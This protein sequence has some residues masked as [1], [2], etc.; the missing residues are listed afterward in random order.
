MTNLQAFKASCVVGRR[1]TLVA[2]WCPDG[3]QRTVAEN[4]SRGVGF[5][6]TGK[7]GLKKNI[8]YLSWPKSA[9]ISQL[10]LGVF[11]IRDPYMSD[12]LTYTFESAS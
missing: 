12:V 10:T 8:S 3:E 5:R 7:P 4:K 2:T 6:R 1:V 9:E 11:V